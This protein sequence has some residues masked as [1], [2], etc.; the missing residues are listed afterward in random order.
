MESGVRTAGDERTS[1]RKMI[2]NM[3]RNT[4]VSRKLLICVV[5][6]GSEKLWFNFQIRPV[7]RPRRKQQ[8]MR[9]W[10]APR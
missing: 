10:T 6:R 9:Q 7:R 2:K 4:H 1:R 8:K 5:V 3:L